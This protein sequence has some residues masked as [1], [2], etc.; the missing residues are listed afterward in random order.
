MNKVNGYIYIGDICKFFLG[1]LKMDDL[2]VKLYEVKEE[3]VCDVFFVG[4]KNVVI[5]LFCVELD[6]N[7]I[8]ICVMI[9]NGEE[10]DLKIVIKG[11][12]VEF[13]N[14]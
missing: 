4:N 5:F 7:K 8:I 11:M 12:L 2:K 10:D 13:I 1:D 14:F 3:I 9:D 6:V